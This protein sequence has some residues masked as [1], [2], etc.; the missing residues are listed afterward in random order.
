MRFFV[1]ALAALTLTGCAKEYWMHEP[2]Q[3]ALSDHT[4]C[5]DYGFEQG[6]DLY[7]QCRMNV[8]QNRATQDVARRAASMQQ[9]NMF[10][11]QLQ[12]QEAQRRAAFEASRPKTTQCQRIGYN[13][14]N[15]TTW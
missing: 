4:T 9:L 5:K 7:A 15:C 6:T 14:L 12:Q 1:L 11:M 3:Q 13:Q 10:S 8:D 2:V